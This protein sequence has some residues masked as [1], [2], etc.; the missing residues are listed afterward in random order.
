MAGRKGQ[1]RLLSRRIRLRPGPGARGAG[2]L[3]GVDSRAG[4]RTSR[5]S[6]T[7]SRA[8]SASAGDTNEPLGSPLRPPQAGSMAAL[9]AGSAPAGATAARARS[10]RCR[11]ASRRWRGMAPESIAATR[12]SMAASASAGI[13]I[14]SAPAV[15]ASRAASPGPWWAVIASITRA[16]VTI[17]PSKPSSCRSRPSST[18]GER[19]AGRSPSRA[20][21][22][23]WAVITLATPAAMA[24]RKGGSSTASSRS[25]LWRR[26]GSSRWESLLVSPWPGKCLA[27]QSTPSAWAPRRKAAARVAAVAGS[28][29]QARTLI[30]G[31]AGLL[32]TSQTGP[33]TQ[34]RPSSRAWR[35]VQ[36][37]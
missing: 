29:P 30:T 21:I 9:P 23:R 12:A 27:Q 6:S 13:R 15:K 25:R 34:F 26:S 4:P 20:A 16:S 19:V 22:S 11:L 10:R 31:L 1:A 33:S 8:R 35:P 24:A 28:S 5:L 36:R 18:A 17:S 37:P 7:S 32:L 14:R 3:D 2:G